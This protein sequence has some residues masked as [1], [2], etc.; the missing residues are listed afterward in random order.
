MIKPIRKK[1]FQQ[2]PTLSSP[3]MKPVNLLRNI[4]NFNLMSKTQ[5]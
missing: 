5:T 4:R 3:G 1:Q 2:E